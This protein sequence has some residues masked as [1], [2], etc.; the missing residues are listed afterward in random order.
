MSS[1]GMIR[2]KVPGNSIIPLIVIT[3]LPLLL[4]HTS[5]LRAL[6]GTPSA[7]CQAMNWLVV[8]TARV[9]STGLSMDEYTGK[10][11]MAF[12]TTPLYHKPDTA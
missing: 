4:L 9:I 1:M 6:S 2:D 5:N 3:L 12:A 7:L 11:T 8:C 10:K